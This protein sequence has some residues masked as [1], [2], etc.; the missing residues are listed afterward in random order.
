MPDHAR[1]LLVRG[2]FSAFGRT[3]DSLTTTSERAGQRIAIRV[4]GLNSA[5]SVRSVLGCAYGGRTTPQMHLTGV[6]ASM[7]RAY[8]D[9]GVSV[10]LGGSVV[11]LNDSGGDAPVGADFDA[12]VFCPRPGV[13]AALPALISAGLASSTA[14]TGVSNRPLTSA[15]AGGPTRSIGTSWSST[16]IPSVRSRV[17]G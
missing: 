10:S 4:H 9:R 8:H 16:Q 12:L 14:S 3:T 7:I 15:R 2:D 5:R 17:N 6:S 11:Q 13:A 1:R